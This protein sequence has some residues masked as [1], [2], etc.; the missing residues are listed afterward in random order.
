M[1]IPAG[2]VTRTTTPKNSRICSQPMAVTTRP[3][4]SEALRLQH[5]VDEIGEQKSGEHQPDEVS[6]SHGALLEA[7]A[8]PDVRP[9]DREERQGHEDVDEIGHGFLSPAPQNLIR[10]APVTRVSSLTRSGS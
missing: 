3:P 1:K 2:G 5:G 7:L 10:I 8:A 4:A 6:R 9:R